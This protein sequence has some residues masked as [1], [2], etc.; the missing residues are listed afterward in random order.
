MRRNSYDWGEVE[1]KREEGN[2]VMYNV[3]Y[4]IVGSQHRD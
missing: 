4:V 3:Y 2:I 1:E